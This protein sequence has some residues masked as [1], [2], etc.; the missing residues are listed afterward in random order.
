VSFIFISFM[1]LEFYLS[2][3]MMVKP[4]SAMIPITVI[5]L[6]IRHTIDIIGQQIMI[7]YP[8][9][10]QHYF[11][12]SSFNLMVI[13]S[14]IIPTALKAI[15][16]FQSFISITARLIPFIFIK[17]MKS[18]AFVIRFAISEV[19]NFLPIVILIRFIFLNQ[20]LRVL[21]SLK[22]ISK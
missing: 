16:I 7:F 3:Y 21:V 19:S 8:F 5:F 15:F 20:I 2:F 1:A 9:Y 14:P 6:H 10:S 4:V 22:T 12:F 17:F 13:F 18:Q 11:R